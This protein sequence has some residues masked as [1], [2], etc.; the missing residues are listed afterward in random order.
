MNVRTVITSLNNPQIKNLALLQKKAK[1]RKEQGLFV[2]EGIKM[3]E[4]ARDLGLLVKSYLSESFYQEKLKT[5]DFFT[6]LNF[7]VVSD[8]I[9]K[10][11]TDTMT[12]QGIMG[13]VKRPVYNL[14]SI[15]SKPNSFL[16]ILE[17][18]RDPGNLGTMIR[19]AEGA[20]VTGIILNS[21]CAD[22]LQ[23]KVVRATMGSIYR[24]PYYLAED[25]TAILN[26]LKD[27]GFKLYAAH[28][29][30]HLYD[31]EGSF[32]GK[33]GLLIGNEAHGLKEETSAMADYLIKIPM[34]GK[35]ES[36]NAAIAAAILMYEAARQRRK[37]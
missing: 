8:Q 30:G 23:P 24:V 18:I 22:I 31:Q 32:L 27:E 9:F 4:E 11:I 28:L 17:D 34:E 5:S 33:C 16:L 21:S 7:E 12:P 10:Q 13:T 1:A 25:F 15:L 6:G 20:G 19:T 14:D 3:F 35:V 36:L 37:K 26:M 29:S 2:V